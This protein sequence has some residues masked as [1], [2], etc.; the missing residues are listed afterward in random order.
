MKLQ[1]KDSYM[2]LMDFEKVY[3]M[4]DGRAKWQVSQVNGMEGC[5]LRR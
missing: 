1:G 5:I 2:T 4:T 3:D